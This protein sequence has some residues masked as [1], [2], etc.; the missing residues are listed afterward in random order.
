M[1]N[2]IDQLFK[3]KLGDHNLPPSDEAWTKVQAGLSKRNKVIIY[4]RAAA[5][6]VLLGLLVS[7][8]YLFTGSIVSKQEQLTQSGLQQPI[9]EINN[10]SIEPLKEQTLA[11]VLEE[12]K[13]V[14]TKKQ[15]KKS[16]NSQDTNKQEVTETTTELAQHTPLNSE[17]LELNESIVSVSEAKEEKAIVIEFILPA[18]TQTTSPEVAIAITE[19]EKSNGIMKILET[20]RDV[21][22][23]DAELGNSL[24]DIK[25][26]L[27]AFDF[28][29]DKTKR[30]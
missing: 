25:N 27:L 19:P 18:I 30:N 3:N 9:P 14:N 5:V 10:E 15:S 13:K 16:N 11:Q 2:H 6:F 17:I 22:N 28:K 1:S 29:K 26:E 20:A 8:W 7:A 21:K 24:R 12:P 23:G 4:W